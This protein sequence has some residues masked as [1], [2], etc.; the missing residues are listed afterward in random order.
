MQIASFLTQLKAIRAWAH[1][2]PD[3]LSRVRH[4]VLVGNG[5]QDKMVPSSNSV[6][7]ARHIPN[8]ELACTTTPAWGHI[9]VSRS[10]REESPGVL[11]ILRK[12]GGSTK[13]P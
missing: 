4:P 6:D 10:I 1:Q 13:S 9:S 11:G 2:T 7:H 5:D 3:D 12:R 8:A